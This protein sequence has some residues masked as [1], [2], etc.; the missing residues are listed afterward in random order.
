[1]ALKPVPGFDSAVT[2]SAYQLA[3]ADGMDEFGSS[4]V[5][6]LVPFAVGCSSCR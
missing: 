6:A 3:E 1:M 2:I 5:V 4:A